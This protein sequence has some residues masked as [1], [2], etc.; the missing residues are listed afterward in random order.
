MILS[1]WLETPREY[2]INEKTIHIYSGEKT[3]YFE[4][5]LSDTSAHNAPFLFTRVKG[6]F[7]FTCSIT[8]D[9]QNTYDAG[10][11]FL[12]CSPMKWVKFAFEKTDMGCTS[13]VCVV[14]QRK[15][16]DANGEQI[17]SPG[18]YMR[19]SRKDDVI[20]L[21]FCP[22]PGGDG[23]KKNTSPISTG[24]TSALPWRMARLFQF[25]CIRD[26]QY[27]GIIAQSPVGDGCSVA[28][29]DL[30]LTFN[31]VKDFRKGV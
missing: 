29:R 1:E 20:G 27:L 23:N 25:P 18:V 3:N 11:L 28:F 19:M 31:A 2:S 6:D 14:T 7:T 22:L 15:S 4:D 13:V 9:F 26:E 17:T 30:S 5:P 8:P 10:A 12:Y 16:D 24:D 21:Y